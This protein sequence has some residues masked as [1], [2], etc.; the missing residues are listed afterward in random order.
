M[1]AVTTFRWCAIEPHLGKILGSRKTHIAYKT[2]GK[3]S[4]QAVQ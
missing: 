4:F 1:A 3:G 2:D